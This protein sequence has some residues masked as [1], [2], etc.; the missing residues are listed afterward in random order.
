MCFTVIH[1]PW[2]CK[3]S[4][5]SGDQITAKQ[6]PVSGA[7][8]LCIHRRNE[9]SVLSRHRKTNVI[10]PFALYLPF[11][12]L[13]H[14]PFFPGK[15]WSFVCSGSRNTLLMW[16]CVVLRRQLQPHHT[17][18]QLY[19]IFRTEIGSHLSKPQSWGVSLERSFCCCCLCSV[20]SPL[21]IQLETDLQLHCK[22]HCKTRYRSSFSVAL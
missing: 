16:E 13:S 19:Q 14:L 9:P 15:L 2:I 6:S 3:Y 5:Q 11:S 12:L 4:Q 18:L 1:L 22:W 8:R 20:T 17:L 10:K 7:E 21:P